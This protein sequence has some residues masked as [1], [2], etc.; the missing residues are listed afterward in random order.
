MTV[1]LQNGERDSNKRERIHFFYPYQHK[2]LKIKVE[3][4]QK[5]LYDTKHVH[6]KH[7]IYS[8]MYHLWINI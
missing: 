1:G 6:F 3:K 8:N 7:T 4:W 5:D 2:R